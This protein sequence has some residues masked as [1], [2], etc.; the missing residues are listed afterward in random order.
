MREGGRPGGVDPMEEATRAREG[1]PGKQ[2]HVTAGTQP[3]FIQTTPPPL[4]ALKRRQLWPE[5]IAML[6]NLV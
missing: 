2:T 6:A 5:K 1:D 4:V 3:I